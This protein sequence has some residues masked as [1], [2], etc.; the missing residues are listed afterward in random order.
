MDR[1]F[2]E[3]LGLEKEA[4]DKV[5]A[6]HGKA[7][8]DKDSRLKDLADNKQVLEKQVND[9]NQA[10]S[11]T[12]KKYE[13]YDEKLKTLEKEANDFKLENLKFKIAH[14]NGLPLELANRLAGGDEEALQKDA[15]VLA[16]FVKSKASLPLASTEPQRVD[17]EQE[18][19]Q[20]ML[21][22]L[23]GEGE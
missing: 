1:K 2:L 7:L 8:T 11:S 12:S 18:A 22:G 20:K 13:G 14:Q 16:E 5:M 19:Y 17:C 21:D 15:S 10:L 9:L 23:K 6:E 3:S 4:I